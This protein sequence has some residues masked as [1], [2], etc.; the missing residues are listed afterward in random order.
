MSKVKYFIAAHSKRAEVRLETHGK[1]GVTKASGGE[2]D[3][4]NVNAL[5]VEKGTT[6]A[7]R[8]DAGATCSTLFLRKED[9]RNDNGS[10][11]KNTEKST[12]IREN[13]GKRK[14]VKAYALEEAEAGRGEPEKKI[15][16]VYSKERSPTS[17]HKAG[18][19]RCK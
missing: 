9:H 2:S 14:G 4:K 1:G 18:N 19:V 11:L 6:R 12:G 10:W 16:L 7:V 8:G 3:M 13:D 5:L 15:S 17:E